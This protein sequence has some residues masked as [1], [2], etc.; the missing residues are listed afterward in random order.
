DEYSGLYKNVEYDNGKLYLMAALDNASSS[1]LPTG[2]ISESQDGGKSWKDLNFP[3][4]TVKEDSLSV[5]S[6]NLCFVDWWTNFLYV[7]VDDGQT[8][9]YDGIYD[10]SGGRPHLNS[11][12]CDAKD[13]VAIVATDKGTNVRSLDFHSAGPMNMTGADTEIVKKSIEDPFGENWAVTDDG[14]YIGTGAV[15]GNLNYQDYASE[16]SAL[17]SRMINDVYA[18]NEIALAATDNGLSSLMKVFKFKA[19]DTVNNINFTLLPAYQDTAYTDQGFYP[20]MLSNNAFQDGVFSFSLAEIW[21]LST[22]NATN[23][24]NDVGVGAM[25][26]LTTSASSPDKLYFYLE[27]TLEI[28]GS[29]VSEAIY[30][31][32]GDSAF[33]WWV[34]VPNSVMQNGILS[35]HTEDGKEYCIQGYGSEKNEVTIGS[36]QDGGGDSGTE[37]KDN[38]VRIYPGGG[39]S[40]V[41]YQME[42]FEVSDGQ[43]YSSSLKEDE[44]T[45]DGYLKITFSAG[46]HKTDKVA[47][48]YRGAVG[49][50][51]SYGRNTSADYPGSLNFYIYGPLTINGSPVTEDVYLAQGSNDSGNNW[52]FGSKNAWQDSGDFMWVKTAD[53]HQYCISNGNEDDYTFMVSDKCPSNDTT[54]HMAEI[55][56]DLGDAIYSVEFKMDLGNTVV[57]SGQPH[58]DLLSRYTLKDNGS[59]DNQLQMVFNAG[60]HESD[61]V[62][63]KFNSGDIAAINTFSDNNDYTKPGELYY[64]FYGDL[65]INGSPVVNKVMFAEES[66]SFH[67]DSNTAFGMYSSSGSCKRDAWWVGSEGAENAD[68][69]DK[70]ELYTAN[71]QCYVLEAYD[72]DDGTCSDAEYHDHDHK[73]KLYGCYA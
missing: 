29:K 42:G 41:S 5:S 10:S 45:S 67:Y 47:D 57:S 4:D 70:L 69:N 3:V 15:L 50:H 9:S 18:N 39:V 11:V 35:V 61:S 62:A 13:N 55:D 25:F 68:G 38:T 66:L 52:W 12:V 16:E 53:G 46:R 32:Q 72:M 48:D 24:V 7:S 63:D 43:P 22:Q 36:C 31:A 37:L 44:Y 26:G 8:W 1:F 34:G 6:N 20:E 59:D 40:S 58:A 28:N 64:Y 54:P 14:L 60:H 2:Y 23:F 19:K 30:L 21:N 27:G 73:F 56:I 51:S 71:H 33:N 65:I 49:D 17:P